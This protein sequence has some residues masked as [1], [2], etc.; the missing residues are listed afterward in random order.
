MNKKGKFEAYVLI[1]LLNLHTRKKQQQKSSFL[2]G[3]Y[4]NVGA[5]F[6]RRRSA[7]FSCLWPALAYL[8]DSRR[9]PISGEV[10]KGI[11]AFRKN[12]KCFVCF[13]PLEFQCTHSDQMWLEQLPDTLLGRQ[14]SRAPAIRPSSPWLYCSSF[15]RRNGQGLNRPAGR[16]LSDQKSFS[17]GLLPA[18]TILAL[19]QLQH[20]FGWILMRWV[21]SEIWVLFYSAHAFLAPSLYFYLCP[22]IRL[23]F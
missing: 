20:L 17:Q 3:V 15:E 5:R 6:G 19:T 21:V 1:C 10:S 23:N 8:T 12:P 7:A 4:E 9:T 11:R 2:F 14:P 22:E 16:Q 13:V 18:F